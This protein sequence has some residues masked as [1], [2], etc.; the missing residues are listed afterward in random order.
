LRTSRATHNDLPL[1]ALNRDC[2][3]IFRRCFSAVART[4]GGRHLQLMRKLDALKTPLDL[5]AECSAVA[6][7]ESAKFRTYAGLAC[8]EGFRVGVSR[9]HFQIPPYA[10][11]VFLFDAEQINA[12]TAGDLDH[13]HVVFVGHI[14]DAAQLLGRRHA[15]VH[16]RHYAKGAVFL[17]VG[18]NTVI[19]E[20]RIALVFV[21]LGPDR[22]EQRSESGLAAGV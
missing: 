15:A 1:A 9:G 13:W 7:A 2:S 4:S 14:G 17:N 22:F 3:D 18:V 6:N 11:E 12:L 20:A 16:A 8:S 21:L 19:D 10:R 5:N